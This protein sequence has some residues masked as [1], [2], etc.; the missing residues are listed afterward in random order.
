MIIIFFRLTKASSVC[1]KLSGKSSQK[2]AVRKNPVAPWM[3]P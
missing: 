2:E 1:Q 3:G